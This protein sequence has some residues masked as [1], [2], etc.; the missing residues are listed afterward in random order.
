MNNY[1]NWCSLLIKKTQLVCLNKKSFFL[2]LIWDKLE[3]FNIKNNKLI[4]NMFN[5]IF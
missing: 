3:F 4:N 2:V 1:K 5:N